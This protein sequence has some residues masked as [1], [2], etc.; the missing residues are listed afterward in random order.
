[1]T[2]GTI[3]HSEPYIKFAR[4][5]G[6]QTTGGINRRFQRSDGSFAKTVKNTAHMAMGPDVHSSMVWIVETDFTAPSEKQD[7]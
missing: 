3:D 1:V 6:V 7:G 2:P 5:V 4:I